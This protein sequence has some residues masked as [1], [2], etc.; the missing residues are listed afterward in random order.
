VAAAVDVAVDVAAVA[1]VIPVVVD[2]HRHIL[3]DGTGGG[4]VHDKDDDDEDE[5]NLPDDRT[6][7]RWGTA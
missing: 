5:D 1:F 7:L 6:V 2:R 4:R 3:R